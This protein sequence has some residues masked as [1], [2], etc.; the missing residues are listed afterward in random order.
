VVSIEAGKTIK[1]LFM[2]KDATWDDARAGALKRDPKFTPGVTGCELGRPMTFSNM[3]QYAS[4]CTLSDAICPNMR[5]LFTL[6]VRNSSE[7]QQSGPSVSTPPIASRDRCSMNPQRF[8][9]VW[10]AMHA[11]RTL[12]V[13]YRVLTHHPGRHAWECCKVFS[14]GGQQ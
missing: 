5:S 12:G 14:T 2:R 8:S 3:L 9:G 13:L 10:N 1:R 11:V 7:R 4:V 6:P